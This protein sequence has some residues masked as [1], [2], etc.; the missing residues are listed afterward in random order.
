[1]T[2]GTRRRAVD[3][4]SLR[5]PDHGAVKEWAVEEREHYSGAIFS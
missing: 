2:G 3:E 5:A 1:M 4:G